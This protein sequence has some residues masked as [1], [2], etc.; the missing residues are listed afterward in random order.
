[1]LSIYVG[2]LL[3]GGVLLGAS[4]WAATATAR[5]DFDTAAGRR[6]MAPTWPAGPRRVLRWNL[7]FL[8][9]RFWAF[10]LAFFGLSRRRADRCSGRWAR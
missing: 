7:P 5:R 9:L 1:M 2:S 3:F 10:A 6:R 4:C 8:S